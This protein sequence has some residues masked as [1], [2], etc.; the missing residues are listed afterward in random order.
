M[1][2]SY[3]LQQA[4]CHPA[5]EDLICDAQINK[6][7]IQLVISAF[8]NNFPPEACFHEFHMDP[9]FTY[10]SGKKKHVNIWQMEI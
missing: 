8:P 1:E 7:K 6:Y 2:A 4:L 10:V 3:S 9:T 5:L